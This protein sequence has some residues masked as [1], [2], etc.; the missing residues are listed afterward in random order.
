MFRLAFCLSLLLHA[1]ILC[2]PRQVGQVPDALPLPVLTL[3]LPVSSAPEAPAAVRPPPP[4]A[5]PLA[6]R[7]SPLPKSVVASPTPV[8]PPPAPR[9]DLDALHAQ[10]R[11]LGR[12]TAAPIAGGVIRKT[13]PET[14]LDLVDHPLVPALARRLGRSLTIVGEQVMADG[15]R[16]IRFSGNRCLVVPRLM[17][18]W[19]ESQVVPTELV[20]TNCPD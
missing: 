4:T 20:P 3:R 9:L 2:W 10:S 14:V 6:S 15:S 17:P 16:L 18:A 5:R 12:T 1:L 19:R 7:F 11:E 8:V 13:P